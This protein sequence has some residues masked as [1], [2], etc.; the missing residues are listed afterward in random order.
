MFLTLVWGYL[1]FN[2]PKGGNVVLTSRV[3]ESMF[4]LCFMSFNAPKGGNVVLTW[5]NGQLAAQPA[6]FNAPKGG[7]VVLTINRENKQ[8]LKEK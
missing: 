4:R 2:A 1:R 3:S 7:N 6:R 8:I 5:L